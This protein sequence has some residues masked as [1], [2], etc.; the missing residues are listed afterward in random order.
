MQGIESLDNFKNFVSS[1]GGLGRYE[2]TY[3]VHAAEGETVV[4]MEVFNRNPVLKERLFESMRDM[5]IEPER[6][7]VGNELN[8]INPITG[9]P[10][11]FLKNIGKFINRVMPGDTEKYLPIAAGFIPGLSTLAAAGFGAGIGAV[12]AAGRDENLL[13]G[14]LTGG[15]MGGGTRALLGAYGPGNFKFATRRADPSLKT[16][17]LDFQDKLTSGVANFFTSPEK[18]K[19]KE[20]EKT[21]LEKAQNVVETSTDIGELADAQKILAGVTTKGTGIGSLGGLG[22]GLGA[23]ALLGAAIGQPKSAKVDRSEIYEPEVTNEFAF[24]PNIEFRRPIPESPIVRP[25]FDPTFAA[26]GGVMD[27]RQGGES[28][29]PAEETVAKAQNECMKQW[30]SWRH[31]HNGNTRNNTKR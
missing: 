2:D 26:E 15:L 31:K 29:G 17:G 23:T 27:L 22:L 25:D 10:E 1:I 24:S 3:I 5:G 7:V 6:Y 12:S 28:E 9:Q 30:I 21:I 19:A 4:P 20:L 8:S 16:L 13:Q 11:F 14:A 18:V